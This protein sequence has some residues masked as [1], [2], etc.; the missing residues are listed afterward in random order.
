MSSLA[1]ARISR[2]G[3]EIFSSLLGE[4]SGTLEAISSVCVSCSKVCIVASLYLQYHRKLVVKNTDTTQCNAYN[5]I[6][7]PPYTFDG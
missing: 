5:G 3:L 2:N 1:D 7:R 6:W 4:Y